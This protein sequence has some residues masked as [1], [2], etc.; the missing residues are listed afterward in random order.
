MIGLSHRFFLSAFLVQTTNN[1]GH[2]DIRM[3]SITVLFQIDRWLLWWRVHSRINTVILWFFVLSITVRILLQLVDLA[4]VVGYF[5]L[6]SVMKFSVRR[7]WPWG[8][9]RWQLLDIWYH[10]FVEVVI[11]AFRFD[12]VLWKFIGLILQ[13]YIFKQFQWF[14]H[15]LII[16]F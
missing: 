7:R 15:L 3:L 13:N 8:K 12:M 14:L 6:Q 9:L 1:T 11:T 4:N 10:K 2:I 5:C 16:L